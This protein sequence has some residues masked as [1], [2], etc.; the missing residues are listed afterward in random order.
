MTTQVIT[1]GLDDEIGFVLRLMN[2][3]CIRHMPVMDGGSLVYMM[4]IREL[5]KAYEL[6]QIEANTDPLT[7]V[8]N[9][10]P[11]LKTMKSEFT[12]AQLT[13]RPLSVAMI[14]LDHFKRV[15]DTYGHDAGD[16][17]LRK[18]SDLL[19][20]EFRSIDLIGRLGG[21]EF[22]IVFP[23]T[24]LAGAHIA[25][26][27]IRSVIES[28]PIHVDGQEIFVTASMGIATMGKGTRTEA[29]L[30]KLADEQLYEAKTAG[31]NCVLSAAA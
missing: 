15:N 4:S 17:V 23:Q 31:R 8:S 2:S 11:F 28:T 21:E 24:G 7:E 19:I 22:A 18:V 14:D 29:E 20:M 1:C 16:E 25:C 30:L 12:R 13:G 10:R 9:R 6:L 3:N 5:T 27:R 26:D